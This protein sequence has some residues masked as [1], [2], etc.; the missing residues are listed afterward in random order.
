MAKWIE[1]IEQPSKG[2]TKIFKVSA[3]EGDQT[4]GII[5]WFGNW[6]KY[7]FYPEAN[8]IFEKDCLDDISTFLDDLMEQRKL[9]KISE[10][11]IKSFKG[12]K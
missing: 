1:F 6:R 10:S 11:R 5:K 8:T 9:K 3:K 12:F 4:L 7:A 2:V